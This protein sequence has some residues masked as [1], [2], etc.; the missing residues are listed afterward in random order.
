MD[1]SSPDLLSNLQTNGVVIAPWRFGERELA[2]TI[3]CM[4]ERQ[5]WPA[6]VACRL[7]I[8]DYPAGGKTMREAR[9]DGEWSTFAPSME[10]VVCA[11]HWLECAISVFPLV[12]TYFKGDFPR[13]YSLL[14]FWTQPGNVP[15]VETHDWH[16]DCDDHKQLGLFMFGT[17]VLD[18]GDGFHLYQ[19]GSQNTVGDENL[20]PD[21]VAIVKGPAGTMFLEQPFGRHRGE[22]PQ[23]KPRLF[24][25]ARYGVSN[26]PASYQWSD[27]KPVSRDLI[28]D[29]YPADPEIQETIRLVVR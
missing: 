18:E 2:E 13:L 24:M 12:K 27:H 16:R 3:A 5:V 7:K 1:W 10:T 4:D 26:P 6:H 19:R 28:G 20:P 14:C 23:N 15:Y 9:A 22:R 11:P 29:R 8:P 21:T 17:D 25:W